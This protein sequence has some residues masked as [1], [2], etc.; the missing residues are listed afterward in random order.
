[1]EIALYSFERFGNKC[2][3][4]TYDNIVDTVIKLKERK[5]TE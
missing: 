5:N 1:M 2:W 4:A 3:Y